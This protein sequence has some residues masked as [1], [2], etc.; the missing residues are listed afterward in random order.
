MTIIEKPDSNVIIFDD[1]PPE[2]NAMILAL[3]S[4]S[5]QSV[6]NHRERVAKIGPDKFMGQY[7]VGYGHQSIGDCGTTN[8]CLE[9]VSMLAAKAIQ[10]NRLY[11]G[12]EAST[13]Y[14]PMQ[15]QAVLNPLGTHEGALIQEKWMRLYGHALE[16]LVPFLKEKYAMKEGE[17][18]K[19]Y[20][21]AINA[22]AFDI[23]RAFLPAGCTTYVGW[24]STLRQAW[25]HVNDMLFHPL[26]E[27][28]KLAE[29]TL[30]QLREKYPNSFGFERREE[31]D[32]YNNYV[33]S[34][35][36]SQRESSATFEV[37]ANGFCKTEINTHPHFQN[38]LATRPR[39]AEVPPFF[40]KFGTITF[41]FN[42]DFGSF[43]DIQRHRSCYQTMPLLTTKLG[44]H[45]WY[46]ESL[47]E[48][49]RLEAEHTISQQK[50]VISSI[51]DKAVAQY[52]TAMG[53]QVACE[54][55]ASL[56][57]AIYIAELRSTPAVHPTLRPIA[58]QMGNKLQ[59]LLPYMALYVNY[60]PDEW[61]TIRG[62]HD[63]VK[64]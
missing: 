55:V 14:L 44:F 15:E 58:Q 40:E 18:E 10:N 21:K 64:K 29:Q 27:V 59:E 52:Y 20:E 41:R 39:R 22:R 47:P 26:E 56:P 25:D 36:F 19:E 4:R 43:R 13:R 8:I 12:Q 5:P 11:N 54:L 50:E 16:V 6:N 2:A 37:D 60:S 57:S 7:Y 51:E 31:I 28:R 49:F 35:Y 24:H 46:L 63:I 53:F 23:A 30:A 61:S 32:R 17:K 42:L 45:S 48:W 3:Y 62:G 34:I 33:S 1:M 38:I 9:N